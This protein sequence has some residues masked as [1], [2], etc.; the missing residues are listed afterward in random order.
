MGRPSKPSGS[1]FTSRELAL[2]AGLSPRNFS[3][4]HEEGLAP[5]PVGDSGG[6]GGHRTYGSPALAQAALI[7]AL[8]LAGFE[9]LVAARLAHAFAE[10]AG[11]VH[12][13]LYSNIQIYIQAPYNP[14]PGY[15][16]WIVSPTDEVDD[17]FW[18]HNRLI[19]SVVD[20][21]RAVA[22]VGDFLIDIADHEFVLTEYLGSKIKIFSPVA[23]K[24]LDASPDYRIT[25]RGSTAQ[26]VAITDEVDSLDFSI[27]PASA[28][29]YK[30][31]QEDYLAARENAVTRV[32]V[33]VS[34]AIRNAF[35][36]VA[37]DRKL[38]R[39]VA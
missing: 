12:G 1:N 18:V 21:R 2:A 13:R 3:L 11:H 29:R 24:G 39:R 23:A 32:R 7:G 28:A 30:A 15:R 33:N 22:M 19:D 38:A 26:I 10:E 36:L 34:L 9:L 20:Y 27:S 5:E 35:D 4:L 8:H 6:R 31:L 17:D 37:D 25:G 16:P 14:K